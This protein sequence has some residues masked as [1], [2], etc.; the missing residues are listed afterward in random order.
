[1]LI[2]GH[3]S[4]RGLVRENNEDALY[5]ND[6]LGVYILAD[7]M[8]GHQGGEIASNIAVNTI[9]KIIS[10]SVGEPKRKNVEEIVYTALHEANEEIILLRKNDI[11]LMNM[12]TTIIISL[13]VDDVVNY[14][15]LGDS[16]TYLYKKDDNLIQLT[17]DDSLVMEMVKQG[18]IKKDEIRIHSLRNIVTRYLG[19]A[20]LSIPEVHKCTIGANDCIILCSD[21]LTNMLDDKE[22][23]SILR[24]NIS[25]GPQVVCNL[26]VESANMK[27][28]E[29]N[30]SVIIVQY[31]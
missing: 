24:S 25:M 14:I 26:L 20:R 15:H 30:I 17:T 19:E 23:R 1:M 13:F 21:G 22:I 7:G 4:D 8:G 12:A 9:A 10:R 28:G 27:G 31:K 6:E 16:R 18:I 3:K 2:S 11:N 29:D 5:A